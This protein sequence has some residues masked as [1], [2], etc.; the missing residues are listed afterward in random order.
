[1]TQDAATSLVTDPRHSGNPY[2]RS[3]IDQLIEWI[4]RIPGPSWLFYAVALLA[5]ALA[6]NAVFWLDG[7]LATGSFD[8]VRVIDSVF[9]VFFGALYVDLKLL[10][11][12]SFHIFRPLLKLPESDLRVMEF[13]LTAL[14]RWLGWL[15]LLVGIG[16]GIVS[17]RSDPSAYGLDMARTVLPLIYQSAAQIFVIASMAAL[18]LQT[19]RQLR[20]VNDLHRRASDIDLFHLAPVHAFASLTA[21]AGT[22]LILFMLFNSVLEASGI[23]AAPLYVVVAI[24]ALA[25]FVFVMPLLGMRKRLRDEK[26]RLLTETNEAIKVTIGRIHDEA[27]SDK[28][29][30]ISG[31]NAAMNALIAERQLIQGISIWPWEASTSR[32]FASTLLLPIVIW[33]VTRL[34]GRFI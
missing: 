18:I 12:R 14:P 23:P 22:G 4:N 8:V 7:S 2:A 33:L 26:A 13:R 32:G 31:M 16:L 15:A 28:Y 20:L 5:F 11:S 29:E 3:W 9:I 34:L 25:I 6:N 1:M 19:I 17:V 27:S 10:A 30:K 21:R 24:G